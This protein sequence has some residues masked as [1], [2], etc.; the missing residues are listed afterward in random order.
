MD[1]ALIFYV[2]H[3]GSNP[4]KRKNV[5][6]FKTSADLVFFFVLLMLFLGKD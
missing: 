2:I 4:L 3:K 5:E 6:D 1:K